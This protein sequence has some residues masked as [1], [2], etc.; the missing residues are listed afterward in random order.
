MTGELRKQNNLRNP[1]ICSPYNPPGHH[2]EIG[3]NGPTGTL[4]PGH[5]PNESYIPVPVSRKGERQSQPVQVAWTLTSRAS[6]G[7]TT[8]SSTTSVASPQW[9][10]TASGVRFVPVESVYA[11][12]EVKPEFSGKYLKAARQKVAILRTLERTSQAVLKGGTF[13]AAEMQLKPIIGGILTIR[14]K[15]KDPIATLKETQP[16]PGGERIPQHR[17]LPG[18]ICF[19]RHA[20]HRG[21]RRPDRV[22]DPSRRGPAHP[23]CHPLVQQLQAVGSVP[24][25]DMTIYEASVLPDTGASGS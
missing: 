7:S 8:H 15:L 18:R 9:F 22:R 16:T 13:T 6:A 25:V 24:A 17:N 14:P 3:P 20:H 10:G 5:R 23:L 12:F 2:F 4:L 19:G 1:I 21:R 11:V